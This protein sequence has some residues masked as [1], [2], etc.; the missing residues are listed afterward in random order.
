MIQMESLEQLLIQCA[1]SRTD[2][3]YS[4]E[5]LGP[6]SVKHENILRLV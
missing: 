6:R 5:A 1:K 2:I 3:S 4:D